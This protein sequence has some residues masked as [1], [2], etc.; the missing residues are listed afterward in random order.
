MTSERRQLEG[1]TNNDSHQTN[2]FVI[3]FRAAKVHGIDFTLAST[4]HMNPSE[5]T[6]QFLAAIRLNFQHELQMR[7]H[8]LNQVNMDN[9][10]VEIQGKVY[11]IMPLY[12]YFGIVEKKF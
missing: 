10:W 5:T 3:V 8:I 4:F 7:T 11:D 12:V 6:R 2:A 1:I 9:F